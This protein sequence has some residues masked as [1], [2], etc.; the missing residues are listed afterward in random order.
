MLEPR[1]EPSGLVTAAVKANTMIKEQDI[2][3]IGDPGD[4]HFVN[5]AWQ[6]GPANELSVPADH[7]KD[8][9]YGMQGHHYAFS[10]GRCYQDVRVRFEF[11]L[12][13]HCDVGINLRAPEKL[14]TAVLIPLPFREGQGEGRPGEDVPIGSILVHATHALAQ[15]TLECR[16]KQQACQS[17][18][19]NSPSRVTL[20]R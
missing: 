14:G 17:A 13:P 10:R 11:K 1:I 8:D 12:V 16:D 4:W 7:L 15:S 19:G 6:D 20:N 18:Y 9:G 3:R 2:V 5:A